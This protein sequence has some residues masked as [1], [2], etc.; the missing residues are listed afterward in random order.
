[1]AQAVSRQPHL[2][3]CCGARSILLK[4]TVHTMSLTGVCPLST[5]AAYSLQLNIAVTRRTNGR[6]LGTVKK[7]Q[8][9]F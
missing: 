6:S 2:R 9:C 3:G 1:M 8:C 7:Q 5:I 4:F